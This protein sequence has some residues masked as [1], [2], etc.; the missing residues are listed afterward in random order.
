VQPDALA[1]WIPNPRALDDAVPRTAGWTV[2]LRRNAFQRDGDG[3]DLALSCL[4]AES[5]AESAAI[6]T[7]RE[8]AA[9]WQ[10][11]IFERLHD[12]LENSPTLDELAALVDLHRSHVARAFR[13]LTGMTLGDY[14]RR[15]QVSKVIRALSIGAERPLADL[16][17][18]A[19][20]AD[21]S[22]MTRVIKRATGMTPGAYRA[23]IRGGSDES[24]SP[25]P[26]DQAAPG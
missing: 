5:L 18:D 9:K 2:Q 8:R 21:Q 17:L 12:D 10:R 4:V 11:H 20:F 19:G 7:P 15:L 22:H 6:R 24:R 16:A 1:T 14:R 13:R 23:W 3:D 25:R 26:S